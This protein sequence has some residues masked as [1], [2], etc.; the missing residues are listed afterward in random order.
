MTDVEVVMADLWPTS[1]T[2]GKHPI[3]EVRPQL[4]AAGILS[5]EQLREA[6]DG[7]RVRA[8]GQVTHRQRSATASGVTFMNLEDE[9]G[10]I[11]VVISVAA[12]TATPASPATPAPSS[13]AA[14]SNAPKASSTSSPTASHSHQ[15]HSR[16]FR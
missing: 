11:N 2:T 16:D 1:M 13:S 4:T 5:A 8:A 6:E 9:T 3:E 7:T 15:N 14:A 10:M 12:G